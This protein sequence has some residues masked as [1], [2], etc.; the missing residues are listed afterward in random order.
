M[1]DQYPMP[2]EEAMSLQ[3]QSD[4]RRLETTLNP[5]GA[6]TWDIAR[7]YGLQAG[8]ENRH[9]GGGAGMSTPLNL[10]FARTQIDESLVGADSNPNMN[11]SNE[12]FTT[13]AWAR[14]G[15]AE[16]SHQLM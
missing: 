8:R 16:T 11:D 3:I 5:R 15:G 1:A 6:Q 4:V 2:L 7:K 9:N 10:A 12:S 14:L 13:D